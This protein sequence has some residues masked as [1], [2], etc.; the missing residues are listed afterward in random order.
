MLAFDTI[1]HPVVLAPDGRRFNIFGVRDGCVFYVY[2][3]KNIIRRMLARFKVLLLCY[4]YGERGRYVICCDIGQI[5]DI[6]GKDVL[7]PT[8]SGYINGILWLN[9][10]TQVKEA[11]EEVEEYRSKVNYVEESVLRR[12]NT[13]EIERLCIEL[14]TYR[15][16]C[17]DVT[18]IK[19][20]VTSRQ[21]RSLARGK[22]KEA[23]KGKVIYDISF[24]GEA[25][26]IKEI[27]RTIGI[28]QFTSTVIRVAVALNEHDS[29]RIVEG[30]DSISGS[31]I[32]RSQVGEEILG[33]LE[34]R[35]RSYV[36]RTAVIR[37][38][39]QVAGGMV[40]IGG[41]QLKGTPL[42]G[43][44][45]NKCGNI[46]VNEFGVPHEEF[47][48]LSLGSGVCLDFGSK[49]FSAN[50]YPRNILLRRCGCK[51]GEIPTPYS[52]KEACDALEF[53]C[54]YESR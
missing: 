33:E 11:V 43:I 16:E 30:L 35:M 5:R 45:E 27:G 32:G 40:F 14:D 42:E 6:A 23:L 36:W 48:A 2:T 41:T 50:V 51:I 19:S 22:F 39:T 15:F 4:Y 10:F 8:V 54:K 49:A 46:T 7:W 24:V 38:L 29:C 20:M 53:L 47:M 31:L 21:Y 44:W 17:G 26:Q 25:F 12:I 18:G 34:Y 28:T 9:G 52:I 1:S 3:G 37:Y 13:S